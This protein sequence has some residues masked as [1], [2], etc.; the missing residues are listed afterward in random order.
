MNIVQIF[1]I[2]KIWWFG[3]TVKCKSKKKEQEKELIITTVN[4]SMVRT[5]SLES[6]EP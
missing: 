5:L 1:W 4:L 6:K 3:I 2:Q